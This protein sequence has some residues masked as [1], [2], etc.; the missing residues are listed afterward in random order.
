MYSCLLMGNSSRILPLVFVN[1]SCH[2]VDLE[3]LSIAMRTPAPL[4]CCV[5]ASI[6]NKSVSIRYLMSKYMLTNIIFLLSIF[7]KTTVSSFESCLISIVSIRLLVTTIATR[8]LHSP[9][10]N[11][12]YFFWYTSHFGLNCI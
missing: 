11:I 12:L 1:V 5:I 2:E 4:A 8:I 7:S 6:F 3:L 10:A 9:D